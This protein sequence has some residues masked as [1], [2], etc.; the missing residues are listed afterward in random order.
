LLARLRHADL[1]RAPRGEWPVR[2]VLHHLNQSNAAYVRGVAALRQQAAPEM[3]ALRAPAS[4]AEA[5]EQCQAVGAALATATANVDEETF[6][7]LA[8]WGHQDYSVRS[9]LADLTLHTRQHL[10]Q[11][12]EALA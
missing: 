3:P 4:A 8:E 6:Y 10:Q 11:I 12:G 5:A 1:D 7:R 9:L 2:Q